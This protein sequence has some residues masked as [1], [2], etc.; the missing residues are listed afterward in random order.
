MKINLYRA[1]GSPIKSEDKELY[2]KELNLQMDKLE[3]TVGKCTKDNAEEYQKHM[4]EIHEMITD[5]Y[6]NKGKIE[7]PTNPKALSKL[8]TQYGSL[9][10][11]MED[12]ELVAYIMDA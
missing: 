2:F 12:D 11:C 7:Y 6:P 3:E 8:C 1:S 4:V 9:A 10:F 5:K